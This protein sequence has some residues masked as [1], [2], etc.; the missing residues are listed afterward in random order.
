MMVFMPSDTMMT[1][2]F[3]PAA[4]CSASNPLPSYEV[5]GYPAQGGACVGS[6]WQTPSFVTCSTQEPALP[7]SP[8]RHLEDRE[9]LCGY[10]VQKMWLTQFPLKQFCLTW[11]WSQTPWCQWSLGV[12][13]HLSSPWWISCCCASWLAHWVWS[14]EMRVMTPVAPSSC[15]LL[16]IPPNHGHPNHIIFNSLFLNDSCPHTTNILVI[17][18]C[19][20]SLLAIMF[21][22]GMQPLRP[23]PSLVA[24]LLPSQPLALGPG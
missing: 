11:W 3:S 1:S 13:Y 14:E 2:F 10:H 4:A 20:A 24:Q 5:T 22:W 18:S 12:A 16:L 21:L 6:L 8:A 7:V 15:Q 17:Q 19:G 9:G 23:S